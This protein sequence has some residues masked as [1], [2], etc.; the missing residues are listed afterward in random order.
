MQRAS[1][2]HG[3]LPV[4]KMELNVQRGS[5]GRLLERQAGYAGMTFDTLMSLHGR[6]MKMLFNWGEDSSQHGTLTRSYNV[7]NVVY[8]TCFDSFIKCNYR[9][10]SPDFMSE[11]GFEFKDPLFCLFSM[12]SHPA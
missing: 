1:G 2:T 7:K 12:S 9:L 10:I 11:M 4:K 3:V 5:R 6:Q 8:V